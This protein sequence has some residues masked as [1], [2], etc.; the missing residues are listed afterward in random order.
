ME[1][2]DTTLVEK[3]ISLFG[4]YD[5]T[6]C[7][8]Q[9]KKDITAN[10]QNILCK[11]ISGIIIQY[12]PTINIGLANYETITNENIK[13]L[14]QQISDFGNLAIICEGVY[15]RIM[16]LK[17]SNSY[18][19]NASKLQ[20]KLPS[21]YDISVKYDGNSFVFSADKIYV[22]SLSRNYYMDYTSIT[23]HNEMFDG[24]DWIYFEEDHKYLRNKINWLND[25]IEIFKKRKSYKG[26]LSGFVENGIKFRIWND[27]DKI[28][29]YIQNICMSRAGILSKN[30]RMNLASSVLE[31]LSS[32]AQK[33]DTILINTLINFRVCK[34]NSNTDYFFCQIINTATI[35]N[36]SNEIEKL[37]KLYEIISLN[38]FISM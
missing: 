17:K 5:E 22:R 14:K 36:L 1:N 35:E 6:V 9:W 20:F 28:K 4:L 33:G 25:I 30:E 38:P 34:K 2:K 19:F 23:N 8:A 24:H 21:C 29:Q 31:V 18:S 3:L 7:K 26:S 11:D 15:A 12:L 27:D 10:L 16:L 37:R 32:Y 13:I